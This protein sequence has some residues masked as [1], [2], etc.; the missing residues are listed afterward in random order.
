MFTNK[1]LAAVTGIFGLFGLLLLFLVRRSRPR[2][3]RKHSDE[4][5]EHLSRPESPDTI[6]EDQNTIDPSLTEENIL[7]R[8]LYDKYWSKRLKDQ[9]DSIPASVTCRDFKQVTRISRSNPPILIVYSKRSVWELG[10]CD[11]AEK[12]LKEQF[13]FILRGPKSST[14]QEKTK[15][16]EFVCDDLILFRQVGLECFV[17]VLL[18]VTRT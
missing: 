14:I 2:R 1:M 4:H 6:S 7:Y 11:N 17:L 9:I 13:C 5:V 18:G 3:K 8:I 16:L 10:L 12:G 15:K